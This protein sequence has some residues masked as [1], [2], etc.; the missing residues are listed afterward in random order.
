M[1]ANQAPNQAKKHQSQYRIAQQEV[2]AHG[3]TAHL[4]RDNQANNAEYQQ[5][6]KNTGWEIPNTNAGNRMRTKHENYPFKR[7]MQTKTVNSTRVK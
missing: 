7:Q 6:M 2:D 3:I 1:A 4:A 5:D